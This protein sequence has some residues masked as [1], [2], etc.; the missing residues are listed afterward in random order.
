MSENEILLDLK[1]NSR[2]AFDRLFRFYY[3]KI[4][5]YVASLVGDHLVAED[6][7]QDV[8]LY[9]WTNRKKL[10][11]GKGFH[12]YLFQAS[13]TRCLDHFRKFQTA[14]KYNEEVFYEFVK[15]HKSLLE[16]DDILSGLYSKDFFEQLHHLLDDLPSDRREVFILSYIKGLSTK[17][18]AELMQMPIRTV[19]SHNYLTLKYLKSRMSKKDFLALLLL[20]VTP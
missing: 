16:N 13:Y 11:V 9:V 12:S 8:F 3:P 14:E 4:V 6:I 17:E 20:F 10:S 1:N 5:A 19:E 18:I 15:Q 2:E 7:T